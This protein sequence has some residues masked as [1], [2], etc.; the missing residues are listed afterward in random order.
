MKTHFSSSLHQ[1][2][3]SDNFKYIQLQRAKCPNK[4][5]QDLDELELRNSGR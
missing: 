3:H 2:E 1:T 5:Q 4:P